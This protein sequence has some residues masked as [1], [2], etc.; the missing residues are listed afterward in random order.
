VGAM[1]TRRW[2]FKGLGLALMLVCGVLDSSSS[3][4]LTVGVGLAT[5]GI[6]LFCAA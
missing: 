6:I 2:A 5:A 1:T 3:L 4:Q